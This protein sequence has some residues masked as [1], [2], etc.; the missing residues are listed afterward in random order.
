MLELELPLHSPRFL[1]SVLGDIRLKDKWGQRFLIDRNLIEKM[2]NLAE[3][4]EGEPVLEV[5]A[6]VGTL[7]I[8]L[9]ERGAKVYAVEKDPRLC[10]ILKELLKDFPQVRVIQGD[11]L[12]INLWN[13]LSKEKNWKVVSNPPYSITSSLITRLLDY[14]SRLRLILLTLQKEVAMKLASPP[15]HKN[16]SLLTVKVNL[17][18]KAKVLHWVSRNVFFPPPKV[19]SAIVRITIYRERKRRDEKRILRIAEMIFQKRR[20]MIHNVFPQLTEE[21]WKQLNISPYER[22]ENLSL[23]DLEK[24]ANILKNKYGME[25]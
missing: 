7:T 9:A 21:D 25:D 16:Y 8:P 3:V 5:G 19:D 17:Y 4:K 2:I 20:K 11:F 10:G 6:G 13:I 15:G 23:E 18:G 1:K 14:P 22:G 24:I 12:R